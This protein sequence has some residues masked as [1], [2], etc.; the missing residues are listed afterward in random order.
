MTPEDRAQ[1]SA[2]IMWESDHAAQWLGLRLTEVGEGRS[3]M[4]F[5]VA[6]EHCNGHGICHGGLTFALADTA[7]ADAC[8]SRNQRTVAQ[9]NVISYIAPGKLGDVLTATAREVTLNG[10]S[11]IYDVAVH[12]QAG[13]LIAEFRGMSRMIKGQFFDEE[14]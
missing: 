6:A 8:N 5:T 14:A 11:G 2:D 1:R 12:N 13:D 7:F 9:H 10:R 3:A 4:E